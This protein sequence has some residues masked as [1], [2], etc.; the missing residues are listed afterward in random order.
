MAD[1]GFDNLVEI[2]T[3]DTE[4]DINLNRWE[5]YS[6]YLFENLPISRSQLNEMKTI[7][8]QLGTVEKL[9]TLKTPNSSFKSQFGYLAVV[10]QGSHMHYGY[11]LFT[12]EFRE[13]CDIRSDH[14]LTYMK[15]EA[16]K[17]L[18]NMRYIRRINYT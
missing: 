4:V 18:L 16:L 17:E 2:S 13:P 11:V 7:Q 12:L 5:R 10:K 6:E 1:F 14:K 8:D 15:H 3:N 9:F